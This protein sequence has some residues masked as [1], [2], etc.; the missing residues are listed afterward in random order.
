MFNQDKCYFF[1]HR[2]KYAFIHPYIVFSYTNIG[3]GSAFLFGPRIYV[4]PLV[5]LVFLILSK[6]HQ[7]KN[8]NINVYVMIYKDK[9][10]LVRQRQKG[11][12]LSIWILEILKY[13]KL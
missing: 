13:S 1:Q 3:S 5:F 9:S 7:A 4:S 6:Y 12:I 11:I 2:P 8:N 10:R